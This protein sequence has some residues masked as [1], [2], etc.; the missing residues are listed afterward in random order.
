M[1]RR[2]VILGSIL[3]AL[4]IV[5]STIVVRTM[6]AA[7][8]FTTIKPI[9]VDACKPLAAIA[10]AEDIVI[11]REA[12]IAFVSS[13][14]RKALHVDG[15]TD[16]RGEIYSLDLKQQSSAPQ[17]LTA[18]T[19][20]DFRPHGLSLLRAPDGRR[21]LFAVNHPSSGRHTVERWQVNDNGMEHLGSIADQTMFGSPNDVAA[22]G[23]EQFY[24]TND[25]GGSMLTR[26]LDFVL[27]RTR[28]TVVYF[29]GSKARVVAEGFGFANGISVSADGKTVYV[30]DTFRRTLEIFQREPTSGSL[31]PTGSVF[32]GTGV[33]NIDI[34]PDDAVW[35]A[36][37]PRLIDFVRYFG[38]D[39]RISPSQITRAVPTDAGR[40]VRT[41]LLDLGETI[42]AASVAVRFG[43]RY[44]VGTVSGPNVMSCDFKTAG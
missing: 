3:G 20:P 36:A 38:G 30:A 15:K 26:T 43:D 1:S 27:Q 6:S 4:V 17:S 23:P 16:I 33:D 34:D 37:H 35:I 32:F 40:D 11:D 41:V 9:G 29:D 22:V 14:D 39:L 5:F 7:G 42:S 44:L 12:G 21:V 10:G 25:G 24:V 31:K 13:T 28:S 8:Q 19:P 2:A 18:L